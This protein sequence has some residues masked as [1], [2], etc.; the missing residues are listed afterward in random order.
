MRLLLNMLALVGL[1]FGVTS[2]GGGKTHPTDKRNFGE[3][4]LYDFSG[5]NDGA[6]PFG[7]TFDSDGN[8][9]GT[10]GFSSANPSIEIVFELSAPAHVPDAWT[11]TTL[12][13]IFGADNGISSQPVLSLPKECAAVSP[14]PFFPNPAF[15]WTFFA[16]L[17][18]LLVL[19]AAVVRIQRWLRRSSSTRTGDFRFS[20][21]P[22]RHH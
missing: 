11:E 9:V 22:L 15:A 16:V 19:A 8:L 13:A 3:R 7:V 10:S 4:V 14:K 1:A 5:G 2:C 17:I 20:W 21:E 12:A 18:G 6:G